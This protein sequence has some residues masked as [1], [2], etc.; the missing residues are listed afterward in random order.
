MPIII[1]VAIF[2]PIIIGLFALGFW[3]RYR[4]WRLGQAD[5]RSGKWFTR[6]MGTLAVAF[7]NVRILRRK[8]LYPGLMHTFIFGGCIQVYIRFPK[9]A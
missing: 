8:E 4:L 1:G 6:L 5:N 2:F 3:R 9:E 7:A